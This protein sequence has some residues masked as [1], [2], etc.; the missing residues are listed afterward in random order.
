MQPLILTLST[1]LA[2]HNLT[3]KFFATTSNKDV[4]FSLIAD[5]ISLLNILAY[6]GLQYNYRKSFY[7]SFLSGL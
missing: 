5:Q 4:V 1:Q 7:F 2:V 3:Y 6:P